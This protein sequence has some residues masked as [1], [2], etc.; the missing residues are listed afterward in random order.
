MPNLWKQFEDLLPDSPLLIGTVAT[1]HADGTVT[2]QLLGGG[3][4]RVTGSQ[5][6]NDHVF[7]RDGRVTSEA[8]SLP[9]VEIEI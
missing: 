9:N 8:P 2:V 7:V 5:S 3:L 1:K 6:V 4:L